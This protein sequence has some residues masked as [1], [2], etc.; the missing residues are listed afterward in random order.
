MRARN[1]L[2]IIKPMNTTS[3]YAERYDRDGF[4]SPIDVMDAAEARTWRSAFEQAEQI[5]KSIDDAEERRCI[6]GF[7]H[8]VFPDI[9]AMV[10][11]SRIID[12]VAQVLGHDLLCWNLSF[13]VKEPGTGSYVSWHQDLN[14]WGL[15][16]EDEATAW[17]ALSP[18]TVQS[19]CMQF[20]RGTHRS[21]LAHRDTFGDDNMLTR[22]QEVETEIDPKDAV[23]V[24]LQ[25]GQMSLHHGLL[26]HASGPNRS[27][28]RRIGLALRYIKPSMQQVYGDGDLAVLVRG[29][30][31]YGHF[32]LVDTAAELMHPAGVQHCR[33]VTALHD[34]ILFR[35]AEDRIPG[36]ATAP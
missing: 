17:I 33:E 14:Y 32:R 20:A 9:G 22:G 11:D 6:A 35:G 36:K 16:A 13:W 19:G 34:N 7:P 15:D 30:D 26:C 3:R 23:D 8:F 18:A 27:D 1:G 10:R 21:R 28:D 5:W 25:P 12:A 4:V 24:V 2:C 29:E 31:R